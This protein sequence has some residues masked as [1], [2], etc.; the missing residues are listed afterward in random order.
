MKRRATNLIEEKRPASKDTFDVAISEQKW[1]G[2]NPFDVLG[3]RV[4]SPPVWVWAVI[5]SAVVASKFLIRWSMLK[6]FARQLRKR[7]R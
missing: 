4:E 5:V 1:K 6:S 7:Y 3:K 2:I